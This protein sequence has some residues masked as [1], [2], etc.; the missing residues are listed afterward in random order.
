MRL[1]NVACELAESCFLDKYV[2]AE[3]TTTSS[4]S[5]NLSEVCTYCTIVIIPVYLVYHTCVGDQL[6]EIY[7]LQYYTGFLTVRRCIHGSSKNII[8]LHF[9]VNA[10]VIYG[11]QMLPKLLFSF[12]LNE[13][14]LDFKLLH[15]PHCPISRKK[16]Y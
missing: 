6:F 9:R 16:C 2:K 15:S 1:N 13:K 8:Y 11:H 5:P 12:F 14:F 4:N 3:E 10:Y 7:R